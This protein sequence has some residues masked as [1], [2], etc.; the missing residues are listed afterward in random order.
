MSST[1]KARLQELFATLDRTFA[2]VH[3]DDVPEMITEIRRDLSNRNSNKRSSGFDKHS[4][5][6]TTSR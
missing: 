3:P 2:S 6:A 1:A 4:N 5:N